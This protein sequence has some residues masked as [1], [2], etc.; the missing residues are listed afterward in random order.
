MMIMTPTNAFRTWSLIVAI[1]LAVAANLEKNTTPYLACHDELNEH[2]SSLSY[3]R[4]GNP[5]PRRGSSESGCDP[6]MPRPRIA[7]CLAGSA[8]TLSSYVAYHSI[9]TNFIESLGGDYNTFVHV[10]LIDSKEMFFNASTMHKLDNE[11]SSLTA[12]FNFLDPTTLVVA[13]EK[14]P[15]AFSPRVSGCTLTNYLESTQGNYIGQYDSLRDVFK[16][17]LA[18]EAKQGMRFDFVTRVRPDSAFVKPVQP[19]CT[20]DQNYYY[21]ASQYH[22]PDHVG[23][24]GRDVSD[25]LFVNPMLDFFGCG[26]AVWRCCERHVSGRVVYAELQKYFEEQPPLRGHLMLADF[27]VTLVRAPEEQAAKC[28]HMARESPSFWEGS[29]FEAKKDACVSLTLSRND[30]LPAMDQPFKWTRLPSV[31]GVGHIVEFQYSK[32]CQ[33]LFE[34]AGR[35]SSADETSGSGNLDIIANLGR[36]SGSSSD[37]GSGSGDDGGNSDGA[38]NSGSRSGRIGGSDDESGAECMNE[39]PQCYKHE[40]TSERCEHAWMKNHCR[41][42]CGL[43]DGSGHTSVK[44]SGGALA[45]PE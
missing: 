40:P 26:E 20:F 34:S 41:R 37:G 10:K 27:A 21:L 13:P 3:Y 19:W 24:F 2:I 35:A 4:E 6:N 43:C 30:V 32:Q 31:L 8:R 39:W 17:V 29:S 25:G 33:A 1:T 12:A 45:V 22:W 42:A 7:H 28:A 9:Q 38:G 15:S 11:L 44:S 18:Y 16:L 14:P 5:E 36:G 23:I